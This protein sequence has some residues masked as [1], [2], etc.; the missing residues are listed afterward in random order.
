MNGKLFVC[1]ECAQSYQVG[2][3]RPEDQPCRICTHAKRIEE[4]RRKEQQV[5]GFRL[6]PL[7]LVYLARGFSVIWLIVGLPEVR[8]TLAGLGLIGTVITF[9]LLAECVLT[10]QG[11]AI[12][13]RGLQSVGQEASDDN[14]TCVS[15]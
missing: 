12:D 15:D 13:F 7:L 4:R 3:D 6:L 9:L 5:G 2:K 8:G 10:L 14:S 1:P 11:I